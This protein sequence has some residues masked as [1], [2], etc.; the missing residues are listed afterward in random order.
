MLAAAVTRRGRAA[1]AQGSWAGTTDASPCCRATRADLRA[2]RRR[3]SRRA[4]WSRDRT[5]PGARGLRRRWSG[6][7]RWSRR[8][9]VEGAQ[10]HVGKQQADF[11]RLRRGHGQASALDR[12]KVLA[13]GVDL[14]D[15]RA[16]GKQQL[17]EGDGFFERDLRVERQIEHGR[18]AAGDEEEDRA[19]L[20]SPCGAAP[21]RRGRRQRSLHWAEDGRLQ[22][23]GSASCASMGNW[24][25]QQMPRRPLRR[26]MRSS[27]VSSMGPAA[28]PRAMTKMRL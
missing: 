12:G 17:M 10:R 8:E 1:S 22:S 27:R 18:A 23:S 13:Q 3:G 2:Q 25:E 11:E 14:V 28:L 5:W 26:F 6:R 24:L 4:V 7:V 21:A 16:G 15:G 19:C 9:R 20:F